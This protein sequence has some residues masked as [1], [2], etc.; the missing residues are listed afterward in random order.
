MNINSLDYFSH[1]ER[2]Q[3]CT[4]IV[5]HAT[6][7]ATASGALA[8]LQHNGLSYHYVIP[9]DGNPD[10]YKLVPASK[11][12]YHAGVSLGPDGPNVNNYSVGISFVNL[13][14]GKD[15]Y[16]DHQV[17]TAREIVTALKAQFP[18]L[19]WVTTHKIIAPKRKTDPLGFDL[20]KFANDVGLKPWIK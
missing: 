9:K 14:N 12:A 1:R 5:L 2:R 7:G 16:T 6:A 19:V 17:Q 13:N 3:D 8:A 15:P 10:A 20:L 4:T 11:V 18:Q